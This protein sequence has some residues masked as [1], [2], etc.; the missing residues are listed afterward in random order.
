MLQINPVKR[1]SASD[2]IAHPIVA[3]RLKERSMRDDYNLL[4]QKEAKLN[5]KLEDLKLKEKQ[6]KERED[7]MKEREVKVAE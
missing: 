7:A 4:K 5:K 3:V 1:P 2:L 6:L